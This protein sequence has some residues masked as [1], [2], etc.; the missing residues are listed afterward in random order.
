MRNE[1]SWNRKTL[2]LLHDPPEKAYDLWNHERRASLCARLAGLDEFYHQQKEADWQASAADRMVFPANKRGFGQ[3]VAFRHPLTGAP[4]DLAFPDHAAAD[5]LLGDT[6]PPVSETDP[7]HRHWIIWRTWMQQAASQP[8]AGAL[9][10]LPADTRIPDGSI[11]NHNAVTSAFEGTRGEDGKLHPALLLF[12]IGPVQEFIAQARSTRDLWSGSYLLSWLVAAVIAKLTGDL[13]PDCVISPALRGQPLYDWIHRRMLE[14]SRFTSPDG[15]SSASFAEAFKIASPDFQELALTPN[16]PNRILALVPES[17]PVPDLVDALNE[18]FRKIADRCWDFFGKHAP[19]K[20]SWKPAW[21]FQTGHFLQTAWQLWPCGTIP[22]TTALLE[23]VSGPGRAA[24]ARA[25][26]AAATTPTEDLNHRCYPTREPSG[27]AWAGNYLLASHRLAA[28]RATREF[29]AWQAHPSA[30]ERDAYSGKE[31]ALVD[32]DWIDRAQKVPTIRHLFRGGERL[33]A[34]NLIKRVWHKAYLDPVH[35]LKRTREAFDSVYAIAAGGWKARMEQKL[36]EDGECWAAFLAFAK[37]AH[38][39][40]DRQTTMESI[41]SAPNR[42]EG[43]IQEMDWLEKLDAELLVPDTWEAAGAP[44]VAGTLRTLLGKTRLGPPPVYYAVIALDG[45]KIGA[46]L[47][48]ENNPL[49]RDLLS[50]AAVDYFEKLEGA[51]DWLN[52]PRPVSPSFHL[53]F[54]EALSNFGLYCARRVVEAHHGQLIYSGGDDVLA[55]V[56]AS[57]AFACASGLRMAFRG[58]AALAR[59]RSYSDHF[60]DP[61]VDGFVQLGKKFRHPAEPDWPL[62]VPGPALDVSAGIAVG[63]VKAPLQDLIH[64]AHAQEKRAKAESTGEGGGGLG[65]SAVSAKLLKRS[66]EHVVWGTKFASPGTELLDHLRQQVSPHHPSFAPRMQGL[67]TLLLR[68]DRAALESDSPLV[69]AELTWAL[70]QLDSG[71]AKST[72]QAREDLLDLTKAYL[73]HLTETQRP[74]TDLISLFASAAFLTRLTVD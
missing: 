18:E 20:G 40:S 4:A 61:G 56:P 11:W 45:D 39:A 8:G 33:G 32:A 62:L 25:R 34:I 7:R 36:R 31:E 43:N 2:A 24:F 27:F 3:N 29:D 19:L 63:H 67:L 71:P 22:A 73:R 23:H 66:G 49:V 57:E 42:R 12:Q 68:A 21:D 14:Q 35:H 53:G 26:A 28:R 10:Y 58:D 41:R 44:E 1:P 16:L 37:S 15:A 38:D 50:E 5:K 69:V 52:G 54:S 55:M 65:R 6:F 64:E 60:V 17:Y 72:P 30:G 51:V 59:S 47:S 9:P 48:G 46:R 13:G 70:G 74:A